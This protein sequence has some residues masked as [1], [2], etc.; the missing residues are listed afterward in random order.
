MLLILDI[1]AIL[2]EIVAT[3]VVVVFSQSKIVATVL[4]ISGAAEEGMLLI[5]VIITEVAMNI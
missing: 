5:F 4:A 2:K 1:S 3:K